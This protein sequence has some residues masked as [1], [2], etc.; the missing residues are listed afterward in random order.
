MYTSFAQLQQ[1]SDNTVIQRRYG[2]MASQAQLV[3]MG[4]WL[5]GQPQQLPNLEAILAGRAVLGQRSGGLRNVDINAIQGSENRSHDFDRKFRPLRDTTRDRWYSVARA[6]Q[7][8]CALPPIELIQI[9]NVYVV[10]D[11][12][13]RISVARAFGQRE[14]DAVVTTLIISV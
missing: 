4:R 7:Q 6:W 14:I 10:R 8:S 13:H 12:H 2:E 5:V 11:G 9:D 3:R 1:R